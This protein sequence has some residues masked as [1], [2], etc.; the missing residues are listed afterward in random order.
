MT[1]T[2]ERRSAQSVRRQSVPR[3][4][5]AMKMARHYTVSE[6]DLDRYLDRYQGADQSLLCTPANIL[7]PLLRRVVASMSGV[8]TTMELRRY[9]HWWRWH[10]QGKP[11]AVPADLIRKLDA[12]SSI[13]GAALENVFLTAW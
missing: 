10:D 8:F 7:E 2:P 13:Q 4:T 12:L 3:Y 9:V 5:S 11:R 1:T 6:E